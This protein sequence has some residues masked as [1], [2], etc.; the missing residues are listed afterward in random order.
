[1]PSSLVAQVL[2]RQSENCN[3]FP[4]R[5]VEPQRNK[6]SFG[7]QYIESWD[8][9]YYTQGCSPR[10][11]PA[12][13]K[14]ARNGMRLVQRVSL[15]AI[16]SQLQRLLLIRLTTHWLELCLSE[17][18]RRARELKRTL[19]FKIRVLRDAVWYT[20]AKVLEP[21]A[22]SIFRVVFETPGSGER[23]SQLIRGGSP[24]SRKYGF[25]ITNDTGHS[26]TVYIPGCT[27]H[28]CNDVGDKH[29]DL[30]RYG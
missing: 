10:R 30:N 9:S 27:F 6:K 28:C 7:S 3:R 23:S 11:Q 25:I 15:S 19:R 16:H 8:S 12:Y 1:V 20:R 29:F 4:R 21:V 18:R 2:Q 22:T 24:I 13:Q 14:L 5:G 17:E 26:R